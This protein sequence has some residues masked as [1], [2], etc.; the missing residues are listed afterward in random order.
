MNVNLR[1]LE[2]I[3]DYTPVICKMNP[4]S[5]IYL[6]NV[7]LVDENNLLFEL[8][9][10]KF[11]HPLKRYIVNYP[12]NNLKYR[13]P[14][15]ELEHNP[16]TSE[17]NYLL[18]DNLDYICKNC[19]TNKTVTEYIK[20]YIINSNIDVRTVLLLLVDGLSYEDTKHIG[21]KSI[22]VFIDSPSLTSRS[23]PLIINKGNLVLFFNS[24]GFNIMG[25][26]YWDINKTELSTEIFSC[27]SNEQVTSVD[28]FNNILDNLYRKNLNK[29]FIQIV[30]MGLD[31][32]CHKQYD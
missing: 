3:L 29:T 13:F 16:F 15:L 17:I 26:N 4:I 24:K 31:Q 21:Y 30:S 20:N 8:D 5:F 23:F 12:G 27:F 19:I 32:W 10:P 6:Q 7:E 9:N 2:E 18:K 1:E 14:G 11:I 25:F 28:S 22:P